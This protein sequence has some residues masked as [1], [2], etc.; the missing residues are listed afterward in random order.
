MYGME[1]FFQYYF[2]FKAILDKWIHNLSKSNTNETIF[3]ILSSHSGT[4]INNKLYRNIR[5]CA[6]VVNKAFFNFD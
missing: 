3:H 1:S 2:Y 6:L 5:T 4:T